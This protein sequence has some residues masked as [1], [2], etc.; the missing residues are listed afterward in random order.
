LDALKLKH[1]PKVEYKVEEIPKVVEVK[2]K[3]SSSSSSEEV[4]EEEKNI[5]IEEPKIK[6]ELKIDAVKSGNETE[7]VSETQQDDNYFA[8]LS[9]WEGYKGVYP[10]LIR[11]SGEKQDI[12]TTLI[13]CLPISVNRTDCFLLDCENKIFQLNNKGSMFEKRKANDVAR[14][15]NDERNGK[16]KVD[17][18]DDGHDEEF[19]SILGG[20]PENLPENADTPNRP[21]ELYHIGEHDGKVSYNKVGSGKGIKKSML[22]TND[23]MLLDTGFGLFIWEGKKCTPSERE[24]GMQFARRFVRESL[25]PPTY[26]ITRC[27]EGG[28]NELFALY[29]RN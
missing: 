11:V 20:K 4:I 28:E 26:E 16:C 18:I 23:V 14:S 19:W 22:N 2:K 9:K 3:S 25:R 13:P 10:R 29:C 8:D 21:A 24:H 27:K 1:E 15:L 6:I 7:T 17:V 12:D 5:K